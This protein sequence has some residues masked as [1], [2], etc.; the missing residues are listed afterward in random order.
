MDAA[1]SRLLR[2]HMAQPVEAREQWRDVSQLEFDAY[3]RD[4]PQPL[5]ARPPLACKANFREWLDPTLGTW[6]KNAVAKCWTRG[7]CQGYQ[8]RVEAAIR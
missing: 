2:S 8:V 1:A 7:R 5:E 4:Y 3:L 6:P